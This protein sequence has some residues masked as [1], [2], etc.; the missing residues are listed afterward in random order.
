MNVQAPKL[1]FLPLIQ[2]DLGGPVV[3]GASYVDLLSPTTPADDGGSRLR[4]SLHQ[5]IQVR[6][7][8]FLSCLEAE[9]KTI[10]SIFTDSAIYFICGF[11]FTVNCGLIL[12]N[13]VSEESKREDREI[14][15][16]QISI[17]SIF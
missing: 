13:S 10:N 9:R 1:N 4:T 7:E 17:M 15:E 2:R 3:E 16:L 8:F 11:N 12:I 5:V 14:R 6:G